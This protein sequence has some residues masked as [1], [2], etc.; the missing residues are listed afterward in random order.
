MATVSPLGT[1]RALSPFGEKAG[2]SA[3]LAFWQ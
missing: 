3:L 2:A 1:A